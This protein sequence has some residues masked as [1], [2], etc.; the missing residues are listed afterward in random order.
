[1]AD[2]LE[3]LRRHGITGVHYRREAYHYAFFE[4]FEEHWS[5]H[6]PEA[7]RLIA[8]P[9]VGIELVYRTYP[10]KLNPDSMRDP[11]SIAGGKRTVR[12]FK[13]FHDQKN[14]GPTYKGEKAYSKRGEL[15]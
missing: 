5:G 14:Y 6:E 9:D 8:Q 12:C 15:L 10:T 7:E 1:M 4:H 13:F 2:A 3:W 11:R